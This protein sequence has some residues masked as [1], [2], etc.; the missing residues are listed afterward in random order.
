MLATRV[1]LINISNSFVIEFIN[2]KI[3][4]TLTNCKWFSFFR[5]LVK[6]GRGNGAGLEIVWT[7]SCL[8]KSKGLFCVIRLRSIMFDW[9]HTGKLNKSYISFG[10]PIGNLCHL[11]LVPCR[12]FSSPR[13][14]SSVIKRPLAVNSNTRLIFYSIE[15]R[16]SLSCSFHFTTL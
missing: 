3:I 9:K 4:R 7:A 6:L 1:Q 13:H 5:V 11:P 10:V 2:H 14:M 12:M 15:D 8:I 16:V